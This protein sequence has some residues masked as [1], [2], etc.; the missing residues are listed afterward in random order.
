MHLDLDLAVALA[1]LTPPTAYVEGEPSGVVPAHLRL[2][3]QRVQ[4]AA[5]RG[6][7]RVGRGVRARRAPDR[8]PVDLDHLVEHVDAF[9]APVRA[10]LAP[11][12]LQ[13]VRERLAA[14][15]A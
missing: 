2:R 7:I 1:R 5:V 11:R 12:P 14:D 13:A 10:R 4:L 3:G 15:R 9:D 6:Q 8:P